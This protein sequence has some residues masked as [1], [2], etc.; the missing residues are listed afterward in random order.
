[1]STRNATPR[2]RSSHSVAL[3]LA[4]GEVAMQQACTSDN[5]FIGSV[6]LGND[7]IAPDIVLDEETFVCRIQPEILTR[8]SCARGMSG[9]GGSCHDS[10]SALRLLHV[11]QESPCNADDEVI[12]P[13]PD[14]YLRNFE[15]VRLV[16][17]A[18]PESSPLYLRPIG[19]AAHP[20]TIYDAS[21]PAAE[22]IAAWIAQ[23]AR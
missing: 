18:D 9:E 6:D 20:R 14:G 2:H 7:I 11:E 5:G 23:G 8:H 3:L 21:D 4:I 22:L 1:M 17:Q 19:R 16:V 10:R 15:A 12:G 13:V